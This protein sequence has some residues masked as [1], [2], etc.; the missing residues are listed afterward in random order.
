MKSIFR[1]A[2]VRVDKERKI[3]VSL[4]RENKYVLLCLHTIIGN[5]RKTNF[6]IE[7]SHK[8][9]K[10]AIFGTVCFSINYCLFCA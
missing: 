4:P 7:S 6:E 5:S 1:K 3:F 8:E 2:A 9:R 10:P